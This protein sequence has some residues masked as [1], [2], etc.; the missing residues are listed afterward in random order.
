MENSEKNDDKIEITGQNYQNKSINHHLTENIDLNDLSY[1][2]ND[3][4]KRPS[5]VSVHSKFNGDDFWSLLNE[6]IAKVDRENKYSTCDVIHTNSSTIYKYKYLIKIKDNIYLSLSEFIN[7]PSHIIINIS[8]YYNQSEVDIN[9]VNEYINILMISLNEEVNSKVSYMT[10]DKGKLDLEPVDISIT[11]QTDI[12]DETFLDNQPDDKRVEMNKMVTN[13]N[14]NRN[15]IYCIYG[16][17]D[18]C[19]KKFINYLVNNIDKNVVIVPY[20]IVESFLG[21]LDFTEVLNLHQNTLFIIDDAD[22]LF[23]NESNLNGLIQVVKGTLKNFIPANFLFSYNT[24]N[25]RDIPKKIVKNSKN[26]IN[27][28]NYENGSKGGGGSYY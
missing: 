3:F 28:V 27:F 10:Y 15:G 22:G 9:D 19:K 20:N 4:G 11:D 8:F 23:Y 5:K 7:D 2:W 25:D 17:N 18:K 13:I 24:S 16:D 14:K 1:V 6:K 26:I 21:S 12:D